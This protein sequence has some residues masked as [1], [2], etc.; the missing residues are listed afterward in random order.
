MTPFSGKGANA[1]MRDALDLANN[2]ADCLKEGVHLDTAVAEYEEQI[3]P[4]AR[5]VQ[6]LTMMHKVQMYAAVA[7]IGFMVGMM[8]VIAEAKGKKLDRG[9]LR[10]IPVKKSVHLLAWLMICLGC[11]VIYCCATSS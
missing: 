2:I 7:P 9:L 10:W 3:C 11:M 1:A 6:E 8:D 4:R 5:K